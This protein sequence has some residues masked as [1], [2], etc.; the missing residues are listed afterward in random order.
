[1]R[2]ELEH[3]GEQVVG[4]VAREHAEAGGGAQGDLGGAAVFRRHAPRGRL[5][6]R[7]ERFGAGRGVIG[8]RAEAW[9]S[10]GARA[11]SDL[12]L[13]SVTLQTLLLA[14]SIPRTWLELL[15]QLVLEL[16]PCGR[17]SKLVD[18]HPRARGAGIDHD[19]VDSLPAGC[20]AQG[21]A[22]ACVIIE[23]W[24][25]DVS[26]RPQA[27]DDDDQQDGNRDHDDD[28]AEFPNALEQRV[29]GAKLALHSVGVAFVAVALVAVAGTGCRSRITP[30]FKRVWDVNV[31]TRHPSLEATWGSKQASKQASQGKKATIKKTKDGSICR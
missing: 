4:L 28:S 29:G 12:F 3:L 11:Y 18:M 20:R 5:E 16:H 15:K 2:E 30:F 14:Q 6:E 21:A 27:H 13:C 17:L 7:E 8:V 19:A 31:S 24:V 9:R 22:G 26:R 1:M 10:G 23:P 25:V